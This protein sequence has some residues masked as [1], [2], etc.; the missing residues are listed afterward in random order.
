MTGG[1]QSTLGGSL[2]MTKVPLPRPVRR[3]IEDAQTE[4]NPGV[5]E[6]VPHNCGESGSGRNSSS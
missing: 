5:A 3:P 1:L 4:E 2:R 6:T